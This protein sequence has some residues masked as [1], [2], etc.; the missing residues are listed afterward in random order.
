MT[1]F[2]RTPAQVFGLSFLTPENAAWLAVRALTLSCSSGSDF[3][4]LHLGLLSM[5]S[6][7]ADETGE[8]AEQFRVSQSIT[9]KEMEGL[10]RFAAGQLESGGE[11]WR[12]DLLQMNRILSAM[13]IKKMPKTKALEYL[14]HESQKAAKLL[15]DEG[16]A[17]RASLFYQGKGARTLGELWNEYEMVL[18]YV[19]AEALR[20]QVALR[21]IS[22]SVQFEDLKYMP[23]IF[24]HQIGKIS[25]SRPLKI[26]VLYHLDFE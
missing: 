20:Q 23:A 16:D 15:L 10:V 7:D 4:T 1:D 6:R 17:Q 13:L 9:R 22:G 11:K 25:K 19:Y 21:G 5:Q 8:S 2:V 3:Q 12:L 18:P 26:D 24:L 14:Q